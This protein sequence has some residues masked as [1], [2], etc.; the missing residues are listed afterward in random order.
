MSAFGET[1]KDIVLRRIESDSLNLPSMPVAATKC[2]S[3]LRNP[4]TSQRQ[5]TAVLEGDPVLVAQLLRMANS[6]AYGGMAPSRTIDEALS[7]LGMQRLKT[8]IIEA[9][10]HKL[11][12]SKDP[13]IAASSQVVWRHSVAVALLSRD[14]ASL[15]LPAEGEVCYLA[16]L[17]HDVGKPVVAAMLLE[18]ERKVAV[19]RNSTWIDSKEWA[20]TVSEYHR[21]VGT[22][23][24]SKWNLAEPI[25]KAIRDCTEFDPVDRLSAP[26]VVRFSNALAKVNGL[27]FGEVHDDEVAPVVMIGGSMLGIDDDVVQGL[28]KGLH[29]RVK[30]H[31]AS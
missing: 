7:R 2:A 11:F 19:G 15:I 24:A 28:C 25:T 31:F 8:L 26:N 12:E 21:P 6:A 22:A 30:E 13:R 27:A 17:L 23:I 5:I 16:G 14:T 4:A 20:Q 1:F 9:S 29:D 10:A 3:L 18:A